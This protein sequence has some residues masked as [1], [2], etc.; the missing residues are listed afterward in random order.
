MCFK[1]RC[2][3]QNAIARINS[4]HL[5]QKNFGLATL[6]VKNISSGQQY[7]LQTRIC[8]WRADGS[9]GL[10]GFVISGP[11]KVRNCAVPPDHLRSEISFSRTCNIPNL[12][13]IIGGGTGGSHGPRPPNFH[14]W[15]AWP[16]HL[17]FEFCLD[18]VSLSNTINV[19]S[20]V[21][22]NRLV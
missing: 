19:G 2:P 3:K 20:S 22:V 6:A 7:H 21:K 16:P 11:T 4:K 15:G 10:R 5:S 18:I 17:N 8:R 9:P 1:T 14:F 13:L 12:I